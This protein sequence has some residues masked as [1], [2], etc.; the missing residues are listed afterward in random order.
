MPIKNPQ[1]DDY[2]EGFYDKFSINFRWMPEHKL[3]EITCP[4]WH[5]EMHG[6]RPMK[7]IMLLIAEI[8]DHNAGELKEGA[9]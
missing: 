6:V 4:E 1:F 2:P 7:S 9:K 3:Y 5:T 8:L